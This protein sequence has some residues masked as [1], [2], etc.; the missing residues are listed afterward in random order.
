MTQSP[1]SH[2]RTKE[3]ARVSQ[4]QLQSYMPQ[5]DK[6]KLTDKELKDIKDKSSRILPTIFTSNATPITE[7]MY[8]PGTSAVLL[9]LLGG[10]LGAGTGLLANQA[11]GGGNR[12]ELAPN[13]PLAALLGGLAGAGLG[14][15]SGYFGGKARNEGYADAMTRLPIDATLRDYYGDPLIQ[16]EIDRDIESSR[17]SHSSPFNDFNRFR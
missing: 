2:Y 11:L 3:A 9:G 6:R 12:Y 10:G 15:L 13:A 7:T 14:G 17:Y 5:G 8:S 4:L 16:K 1:Y